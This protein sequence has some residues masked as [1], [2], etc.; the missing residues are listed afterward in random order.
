MSP[1]AAQDDGVKLRIPEQLLQHR[2]VLV[3]ADGTPFSEVVETYTGNVLAFP[4][5]K[6]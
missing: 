2:A 3:L 1:T 5:P 4:M 6:P